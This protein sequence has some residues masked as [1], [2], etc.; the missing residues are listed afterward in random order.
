MYLS[1][2]GLV[3]LAAA[4]A[5]AFKDTSPFF[6]FSTSEYVLNPNVVFVRAQG[7]LTYMFL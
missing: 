3:A 1:K 6:F 5:D 7:L 4:T 2:L